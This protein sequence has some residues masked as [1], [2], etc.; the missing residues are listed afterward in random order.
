MQI[1][2]VSENI[3]MKEDQTFEDSSLICLKSFSSW[4]VDFYFTKIYSNQIQIT[5]KSVQPNNIIGFYDMFI[6]YQRIHSSSLIEFFQLCKNKIKQIKNDFIL[7]DYKKYLNRCGLCDIIDLFHQCQLESFVNTITL[8]IN[9]IRNDIDR[10]FFE[11]LL[12][13]PSSSWCIYDVQTKLSKTETKENLWKL[14]N[15]EKKY[16]VQ[17]NSKVS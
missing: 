5:N 8:S 9:S 7:E 10:L 1:Q 15:N 3:E 2:L 6:I 4:I 14:I 17:I 11:Y 12:E 16:D 13:L